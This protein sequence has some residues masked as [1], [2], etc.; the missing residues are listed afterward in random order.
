VKRFAI[1]FPVILGV[2]FA[3]AY[4]PAVRE[5]LVGPFT[6]G[7]THV[8]GWLIQAW[9][10]NAVVNNNVLALPTFAVQV[11]DMCNGVEATLLMWAAILAFPAPLRYRLIGMGVGFLAVHS[12][13]ILRI[14]SLLYLGA[15]KPEWF[16]WVHW[17]LWDA[18][19]MLDILLI[20][21]AWLHWMPL[22]DDRR[23][24]APR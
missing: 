2:M 12:A 10:G 23:D 7:I 17:Y 8:S 5:Y 11:L 9:G 16:D 22:A 20:F 24:P 18:L 14:V 6:I 13:N 19:I 21:L 15:W 1:L 4:L 3:V